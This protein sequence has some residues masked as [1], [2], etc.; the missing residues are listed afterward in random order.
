MMAAFALFSVAAPLAHSFAPRLLAGA[1][2]TTTTTYATAF[3]D[4]DD[5]YE[6]TTTGVASPTTVTA[7]A[8]SLVMIVLG[9]WKSKFCG[10]DWIVH[11]VET[12]MILAACNVSAYLLGALFRHVLFGGGDGPTTLT[13]TVVSS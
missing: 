11:S 7:T 1:T 9:A 5:Y 2:A 4:D 8:L 12:V 10:G 13:F 6:R 3:G